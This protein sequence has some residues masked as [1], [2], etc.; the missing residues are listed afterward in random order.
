[1]MMVGGSLHVLGVKLSKLTLHCDTGLLKEQDLYQVQTYP[2]GERIGRGGG[3]RE[4]RRRREEGAERRRG[5][6]KI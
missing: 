3:R 1:M 4:R 5:G 2:K 6:R